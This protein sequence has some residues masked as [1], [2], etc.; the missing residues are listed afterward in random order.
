MFLTFQRHLIGL[1]DFSVFTGIY[2]NEVAEYVESFKNLRDDSNR[3]Q[4]TR[5]GYLPEKVIQTGLGEI[6][7]KQPRVRD[8]R[9]RKKFTSRILPPYLRRTQSLDALIP[10]L[11]L[12]GISTG[13]FTEALEAIFGQNAK[14]LSATNIVRLKEDWEKDLKNWQKRDLNNKR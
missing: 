7:I 10:V 9:E 2:S 12:K 13:H 3:R 8:N 4:V 6:S 11:Y 1:N 5:N 14:G